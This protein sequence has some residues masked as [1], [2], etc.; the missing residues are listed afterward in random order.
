MN[1]D[2]QPTLIGE[3][4]HLRPLVAE[5]WAALFAV[6]QDKTIWA[7]HPMH[8]RWQEPVFRKFFDDA[9]A[10][11]PPAGGSFAI[12]DH[13]SGDIIGSTRFSGYDPVAR[14]VEIGWS[15][16]TTSH[17]RT[18]HN[19]EIKAMMMRH[20]FAHV[21]RIFYTV[22]ADNLRSRTAIERLGAICTGPYV[23]PNPAMKTPHVRYAITH[24]Q[25]MAAGS[26]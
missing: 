2:M 13:A 17:W 10:N 7:M 25:A 12:L 19:S 14:D 5:D 6:A 26:I 21:D 1:F 24:A 4:A 11:V 8:D 23:H 22:G 15:F 20:A 16:L 3:K 18:G 9:L